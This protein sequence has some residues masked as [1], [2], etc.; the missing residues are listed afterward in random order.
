MLTFQ[1]K[2]KSLARRA[3]PLFRFKIC[4]FSSLINISVVGWIECIMTLQPYFITNASLKRENKGCA[5][6]A[7]CINH[8][9]NRVACI[10]FNLIVD[11]YFLHRQTFCHLLSSVLPCAVHYFILFAQVIDLWQRRTILCQRR[12]NPCAKLIIGNEPKGIK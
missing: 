8:R 9:N 12:G 10:C 4:F 11:L 2:K 6:C 1:K 5:L 3:V 7:R